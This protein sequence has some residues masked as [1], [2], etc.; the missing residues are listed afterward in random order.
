VTGETETLADRCLHAAF[1]FDETTWT[2]RLDL[3]QKENRCSASHSVL[4]TRVQGRCDGHGSWSRE[5]L[6]RRYD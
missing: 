6:K 1:P 4:H 3:G 2:C 5:E